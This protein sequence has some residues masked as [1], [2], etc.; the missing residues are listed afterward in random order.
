MIVAFVSLSVF[1]LFYLV[2]LSLVLFVKSQF[3]REFDIV[4]NGVSGSFSGSR[5]F[6]VSLVSFRLVSVVFKKRRSS[7]LHN[8]NSPAKIDYNEDGF[9]KRLE[10]YTNGVN[11]SHDDSC[12]DSVELFYNTNNY[13]NPFDDTGDN[14]WRNHQNRVESYNWHHRLGVKDLSLVERV[15]VNSG[16]SYYLINEVLFSFKEWKEATR[17]F[18]VDYERGKRSSSLGTGFS[19]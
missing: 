15:F 7:C 5:K 17:L 14:S 13:L 8:L 11:V 16:N 10:Y 2:Y 19:L 1:V 9:I 3:A 12:P 18:F 4:T 6:V